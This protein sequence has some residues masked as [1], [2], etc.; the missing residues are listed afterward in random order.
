MIFPGTQKGSGSGEDNLNPL[1]PKPFAFQGF[2]NRKK[3]KVRNHLYQRLRTFVVELRGIEPLSENNL[4]G[5]SPGAV[6]YFHS[7]GAARTNT[8]RV[9]VAS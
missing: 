2:F 5:T 3:I 4:T 9:L 6:C 1:L 7:L 8:L